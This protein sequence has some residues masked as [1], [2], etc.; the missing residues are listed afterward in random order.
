MYN[1]LTL[2]MYDPTLA[3]SDYVGTAERSPSIHNRGAVA[4][5][6]ATTHD[7]DVEHIIFIGKFAESA[8]A[9][10]LMRSRY[11]TLSPRSRLHYVCRQHGVML[12]ATARAVVH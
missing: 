12:I 5:P 1:H 6:E 4:H 11:I 8:T 9:P 2:Q 7:E 3:R 10:R